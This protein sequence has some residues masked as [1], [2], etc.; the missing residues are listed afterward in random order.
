MTEN[1]VSPVIVPGVLVEHSL[2]G[3]GKA[4]AVSPPHVVVHFTSLVGSAQGPRRKLLLTTGHLSI[5]AV[6]SDP[7]LDGIRVGPAG[8]KKTAG[9][10]GGSRTSVSVS[11]RPLEHAV[12]WFR[13]RYPGLFEDAKLARQ[14]LKY[15]RDAQERFIALL[16]DGRGRALLS[17]GALHVIAS[18]LDELYHSTNIPSRFE[19]MAAHDGFKDLAVAARVLESVLD[20]VDSPGADT[21][22]AVTEA[23]RSLPVPAKGSRVL[24]WPNVTILPFLA[25]PS[26]FM[27]LKPGIAQKMAAR[28][29][30][31]LLYS[32]TPRWHCYKALLQMSAILLD[33]LGE[34]GAADYIDV[35]SFMWVTRELE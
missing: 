29:G 8:G 32:A 15:K 19:V 23:V 17:S 16:G 28:M 30:F 33:R 14:E 4:M 26:R 10:K 5:S 6:Q 35:Q 13:A 25:D 24:T 34:L 11:A 1:T 31:D 20:F 3:R 18:S 22:E 12:P 7:A 27:V 21:F 2:W 9:P